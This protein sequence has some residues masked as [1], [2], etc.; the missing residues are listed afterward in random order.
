MV[1]ST[2]ATGNIEQNSSAESDAMLESVRERDSP[3]NSTA[4]PEEVAR[5]E[6]LREIGVSY[7]ELE[8]Q[9][10][11]FFPMCRYICSFAALIY[12]FVLVHFCDI[13]ATNFHILHYMFL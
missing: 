1:M 11:L 6:T 13:G 4:G 5:V 8:N 3:S 10:I 12:H 7:K 2:R 9:G